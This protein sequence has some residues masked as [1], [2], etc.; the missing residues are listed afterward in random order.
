MFKIREIRSSN[1]N[2]E[3][4]FL[5]KNYS[6]MHFY[7]DNKGTD[8]INKVFI[9]SPKNILLIRSDSSSSVSSVRNFYHINDESDLKDNVLINSR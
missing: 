2:Q 3:N 7:Q 1:N 8:K 6:G 5:L 9:D 4:V